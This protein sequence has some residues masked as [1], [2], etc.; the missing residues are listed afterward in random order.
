MKK[1]IFRSKKAL[2]L[3]LAVAMVLS[4]TPSSLEVRAEGSDSS[5]ESTV[6]TSEEI[7]TESS[8]EEDGN[9]TTEEEV[10]SEETS[11]ETTESPKDSEVTTEVST[12]AT[13]EAT[14]EIT[15][16]VTTE[17]LTTESQIP[18]E[19]LP[20]IT[21]EDE[22]SGSTSDKDKKDSKNTKDKS[23]TSK[24]TNI[25]AEIEDASQTEE[26][27]LEPIPTFDRIYEGVDY[28][29]RD[30][31]S[32][33]LLIATSDSSIFTYD[34]E[35]VSE[36]KGI[37]LTRYPDAEQ[38]KSAFTYY[39]NK[40]DFIDVNTAIRASEKESED[41]SSKDSGKEEK[42]SD[43]EAD[44]DPAEELPNEGHGEADLSNINNSNDAL[45]NIS[46][47]AVADYS[48]CI[49]LIDTGAETS[50]VINA[51]SVLGGNTGDDNGHGT[52]MAEAIAE[53]N[54]DARILSIKA[55]D[56]TATG[57]V[58]DVYAAIQYAISAGVSVINL[59]MSSVATLDS[60]SLERAIAEAQAVGIRVVASAGNNSSDAS[61]FTPGNI[62][63][64][65]TVGACDE[66]GNR[67]PSS[68]YGFSVD[69]YVAADST[70]LAAAKFSAILISNG[71]D[72]IE[73]KEGVFT[74]DYVE[75]EKDEVDKHTTTDATEGDAIDKHTTTD[76]EKKSDNTSDKPVGKSIDDYHDL[77]QLL[78]GAAP[79]GYPTTIQVNFTIGS[80]V[81]QAAAP[82]IFNITS[83]HAD[84]VSGYFHFT[85]S[86]DWTGKDASGSAVAPQLFDF[87]YEE[88]A[89]CNTPGAP[90]PTHAGGTATFNYVQQSGGWA[91]YRAENLSLAGKPVTNGYQSVNA[92][93]WL[94]TS[95]IPEPK[96]AYTYISIKKG[97]TNSNIMCSPS[98]AGINFT[99]DIGANNAQGTFVKTVGT[100]K[101]VTSD[102]GF[103][104][105]ASTFESAS[106]LESR[107]IYEVKFVSFKGHNYL[108]IKTC[109]DTDGDTSL[110]KYGHSG[111]RVRIKETSVGGTAWK[112]SSDTLEKVVSVG[113]S[114]MFTELDGAPVDNKNTYE[115][116]SGAVFVHKT[117][118]NANSE[119][120]LAGAVYSLFTS[121]ADAKNGTNVARTMTTNSD[122]WAGTYVNYGEKAGKTYYVKE[123]K[124]APGCKLDP[125]VY[126]VTIKHTNKIYVHKD[127]DGVI[128]DYSTVFNY[129]YYK[130][131]VGS[132]VLSRYE[133][134]EG[135]FQYYI[136][137]GINYGHQASPA[138]NS[139]TYINN[140]ANAYGSLLSNT[141]AVRTYIDN[142][143]SGTNWVLP[144]SLADYS[145][146]YTLMC[147]GLVNSTDYAI[148][149]SISMKKSSYIANSPRS[150]DGIKYNLYKDAVA[151][152]NVIGTFTLGADGSPKSGTVSSLGTANK[153]S[154][155][156][157]NKAFINLPV[158]SSGTN[159]YIKE[160][161]TNADFV[162]D[163]QS[164][165]YLL[166]EANSSAL[167]TFNVKDNERTYL[168]LEKISSNPS[169]SQGNPNYSLKGATYEVYR[170]KEEAKAALAS[171][172][173]VDSELTFV[174]DE[175]GNAI[176]GEQ[177]VSSLMRNN[178]GQFVETTLFLVESKAGEKGYLRDIDVSDVVVTPAN[179]KGNAAKAVVMDTPVNDPADI[180]IEKIDAITGDSTVPEGKS[181]EG[182]K[183]KVTFY[184]VDISTMHTAEDLKKNYSSSIV[185]SSCYDVVT[186]KMADG[187]SISLT[188]KQFPLGFI[189]IEETEAPEGYTLNDFKMYLNG[190]KSKEITNN[191]VFVM[192]NI[193]TNNSTDENQTTWYPGDAKTYNELSTKGVKLSEGTFSIKVSN[194]PI[195]GNIEL[196]KRSRETGEPVENVKFLITNKD[197]KEK[198]YIYTNKDGYA[199]TKTSKYV[200]ANY[201]DNVADYD[202]TSATVWF[203]KSS[204]N[205][206][207]EPNDD[208]DALP[209][210]TYSVKEMRCKANGE[211]QLEMVRDNIV[212]SKAGQMVNVFDPNASNSE[213]ANWNV[214]KPTIKTNAYVKETSVGEESKTLA[215]KGAEEGGDF[216]DQTVVDVVTYSKLRANT[217]FT[218]LTELMVVDNDG[219]ANIYTKDGH[220]YRQVSTFTTT[221][222][223]EKSIYEITDKENIEIPHVDPTGFEED[224][225][226]FVVFQKLYLGEY[227]DIASLDEAIKNNKIQTRYPE[228]DE[229]DDMDFFPVEHTEDSLEQ[230][231]WPGD[232]HTQASDGVTL[233]RIAFPSGK[234]TYIDQIPYTGLTPKKEFTV[235]G[236]L[237]VKPGSAWISDGV[238]KHTIT[239]AVSNEE[240]V[241]LDK[242]GN[243]ITAS[244]TFTTSDSG[245]GLVELAFTYDASLLQG[246]SVVAFEELYYEGK[247][248]V[249]HAD[250]ND[251]DET[252][253]IPSF[254]TTT[255]NSSLTTDKR[256][257]SAK[258]IPA[259]KDASITDTIHY[260]NL[261]A[262]SSFIAK[263]TLM[264]K[265]TGKAM[266]DATGKVISGN[267]IFKTNEVGEVKIENS[268]SAKDFVLADG[269]KIDMSSDHA[270][271]L[272][273]GDTNVVFSGYDFTNLADKTGVVFE[274]IYLVKDGKEILVGEHKDINDID[275]FVTFIKI[276][277]NAI[278]GKTKTKLVA[279]NTETFIEDTVSYT[280]A[281]PGKKYNLVGTVHVMGDK[282]GKYK[283]G[284][285]LKNSDGSDVK[286]KFEFTPTERTGEAVVKLPFNSS[287]LSTMDLVVF[288]DLYNE[289]GL[290]VATHSDL[291]DENQTVRIA[292]GHT[293]ALSKETGTH[294]VPAKK[295][296]TIVDEY[297]YEKLIPN[298]SYE[299]TGTLMNQKTEKPLLVN[300]KAVTKTVQFTPKTPDG[301]VNIEFTLDASILEGTTIVVFEDCKKNGIS[302]FIHADINDEGQ[303]VRI[304]SI[305]TRATANGKKSIT[306]D[307]KV[308]IT[309]VCSLT[310]FVPDEEYT[311]KG[312]LMNKKTGKE[313]L[314]NGK[315]ITSEKT[316]TPEKTDEVV[317]L[318]FKFNTKNF[319]GDVVVF[320]RIYHKGVEIATH[321]DLENKDQT[322][323]I[324]PPSTPPET[325]PE[326]PP[327]TPPSTT[328]P[329]TGMT[330]FFIIIGLMVVGGAGMLIF[331]KK[332]TPI[333]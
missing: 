163:T 193:L 225:K 111:F 147:Y 241:L 283:D 205:N 155:D 5:V 275:Q 39:Y 13:T 153:V 128:R 36:Y 44:P 311:I 187:Y 315:S 90:A 266:K 41:S 112:K 222:D 194:T 20:V 240:E 220:E 214:V 242:D 257:E 299:V 261:L 231:V 93:V 265:A 309:D 123:T 318:P 129:S 131:K 53:V 56:S 152:S 137:Y 157:N 236:T 68:N 17:S 37:Y 32:C 206:Y 101:A 72:K 116:Y 255:W 160:I 67:E 274:E 24:D 294:I 30:F 105:S 78:T 314:I 120:N 282:S 174:V 106:G 320:E 29:G 145:T 173:Y 124:A 14:T 110:V 136:N 98:F 300:G 245:C 91:M 227:S 332:K 291:K 99:L 298:D 2:S 235:K 223:Y 224:H 102:T 277:T 197:T 15:T 48:G 27:E 305:G 234:N 189:T 317:E 303:T 22:K 180:T 55:L 18:T 195:R 40:A 213:N 217:T 271:Y 154:Y 176:G 246:R 59:S 125:S 89:Y 250:I 228:Y 281:I 75:S 172:S 284:D 211:M 127:T 304:P 73:D 232:I 70:S 119:T 57:T 71:L 204:D 141:G 184:A 331:R 108:R 64:V 166:T 168:Y 169:C 325:P 210:G 313:L 196:T 49:A 263:G 322:I 16:E 88:Y 289:Y 31:S 207:I 191:A 61:F 66:K 327:S 301:S 233:D 297:F 192:D 221:P 130:T 287:L 269:T 285:I 28:S 142:L 87:D 170:T 290:L 209:A 92:V 218:V 46:G 117:I 25:S 268:P 156:A 19:E 34:T 306:T 144:C 133:G 4:L 237:H 94:K 50:N 199:T 219:N 307:G 312:V 43:E 244:T 139:A 159:Y 109:R 182:A 167:Y 272:C 74:R 186:E 203:G 107:G 198:H 81:G 288:E 258:E 226:H 316:F 146:S 212:I 12:D 330:V 100:L 86:D 185:S 148:N 328:P 273:D 249:V 42:S 276:H 45:S 122:G 259:I 216:T 54:P 260:H 23:K 333:D 143:K 26:K 96:Y 238:D 262:N 177:D 103:M 33:E 79:A 69:Y 9:T 324:V 296:V 256:D 175:N 302:V 118:P 132:D 38:T 270:N 149:G 162:V 82:S 243:P 178:N 151:D 97:T 215:Q 161:A 295:N 77:Y 308:N 293:T 10:S 51:V 329:K 126:P 278:D 286:V 121:E 134:E 21:P 164:Y 171:N 65:I 47:V 326:T 239:D 253:H 3:A 84:G 35:V 292:G 76:A 95:L 251:E 6:E 267:I 208:F 140:Y 183:F 8:T 114:K 83:K 1:F 113:S 181:L 248:I 201:Y 138:F 104:T 200:N 279:Y 323:S 190:D 80:Y 188:G 247:R 58:A 254:K 62:G 11:E 7:S 179:T 85:A 60:D 264:D 319:S 135:L 321:T 202:G 63:G 230:T 165:S 150:L 252:I 158:A 52:R 229:D 310:N 115:Q 280:N